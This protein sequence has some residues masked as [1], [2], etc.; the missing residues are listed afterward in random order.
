MNTS[1]VERRLDALAAGSANPEVPVALLD[2][3][4]ELEGGG[5]TLVPVVMDGAA[6][7]R[8]DRIGGSGRV[9]GLT[10]LGLAAVLAVAGATIYVAGGPPTQN[11]LPSPTASLADQSQ[12]K[13]LPTVPP[14]ALG[15]WRQAYTFA[16]GWN[17]GSIWGGGPNAGV[18][19]SWQNGEI[20]GLAERYNG[21]QQKN[22]ILQSK[23]GT[24]WTC[25][26]LPT[27]TAEACG[28]G[29]C[30]TVGGLAYGKGRW[31]VVGSTDFRKPS[32][33]SGGGS[34]S[35]F[36]IL[37]WTSTDATTW[38]EQSSARSAPVFVGMFPDTQDITPPQLL[39][40]ND[41]FVMSRCA[42]PSQPGLWTSTDGTS[43]KPASYA[44]GSQ[45]ITCPRLGGSSGAGY[46]AIGYCQSGVMPGHDCVAFSVDG[47]TWTTSD[48]AA[49]ASPEVAAHLR[50]IPQVV[51]NLA[52]QWIVDLDTAGDGG[53][54]QAS[55]PDGIHW[56]LAPASWPDLLSTPPGVNE[57]DYH[58]AAY[59]PLGA[60]G[61]W[62]VHNGPHAFYSS[63]GASPGYDLTPAAASTYWSATGMHWQPVAAAPPGWP[64]AVVETPTSI[65][66]IMISDKPSGANATETVWVSAKR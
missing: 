5:A 36:T 38:L 7:F 15:P 23:D 37:T 9:R 44:P 48:P 60:S 31:V 28:P 32:D 66:A 25:S 27:P 11:P 58:P 24:D 51:T 53:N 50:I 3:M 4:A 35:Q 40:T 65:V 33:G 20:V 59:S 22:C 54:Y 45:T 30:A 16:D 43:W 64:L 2:R 19:L 47:K 6:G 55:S 41:G 14:F 29:P 8:R 21:N 42:N 63:A 62:A 18:W 26:Q 1:E 56:S 12:V 13:P 57:S 49:G 52:G 46:V 34:N 10:L 17:F 61:Y 39:A